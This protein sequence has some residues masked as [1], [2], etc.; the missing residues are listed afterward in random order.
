[1]YADILRRPMRGIG[2]T[3]KGII[4]YEASCNR[5]YLLSR[6]RVIISNGAI[7]PRL[8][9]HLDKTSIVFVETLIKY[10]N[11]CGSEFGGWR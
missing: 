9:R 4:K 10:S 2:A 8:K 6:I 11:N 7:F 5:I 1:M 3:G